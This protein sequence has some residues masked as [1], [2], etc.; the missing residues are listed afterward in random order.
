MIERK[1]PCFL[2]AP[3]K[4]YKLTQTFS[5]QF[6]T[7]L[8]DEP[9]TNN[10]VLQDILSGHESF[11]KAVLEHYPRFTPFTKAE[12]ASHSQGA[13]LERG[14]TTPQW[15]SNEEESESIIPMDADDIIELLQRYSQ[16][17]YVV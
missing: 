13:K 5:N 15:E 12:S 1:K 11:K 17:L 3:V 10:G 4:L 6:S 2:S 9:E 16:I 7:L 14:W 8:R